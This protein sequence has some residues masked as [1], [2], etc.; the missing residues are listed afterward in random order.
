MNSPSTTTRVPAIVIGAG[1]NGLGVAR[2]LARAGAPAWLADDDAAR[3]ELR[4]RAARPLALAA[5]HGDALVEGLIRLGTTRFAGQRPVLLLTQEETVR[6]IS[7]QRAR[8]ADLYRFTLPPA[9]TVEALQHK[10]GFQQLAERFGAPIPPLVRVQAEADLAALATLQYP[11]VVKP[12]A[13]N[14]AYS[15]RFRKAYRI[16]DAAAATKLVREILPVLADVVVQEWTEGPDSNIYFCLQYLDA[17]G[18]VAASFTGR[19][20]RS[21][22]PQVGGTASCMPAP[23]ADAELRAL[24]TKF[25]RDT[26]V[27]GMAGMEYKRDVRSGRFRMVEP[28]I[29]RTDYQAEVA[30]LNGVNL[31]YAAYCCETGAPFPAPRAAARAFAWRVRSE[32]LQSAQAQHQD[33]KAGFDDVDAISDALWR[34]NDPWPAIVSAQ[35]HVAAALRTRA[36][37]LLPLTQAAGSKP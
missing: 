22:P 2:S 31:P 11:V 19:K 7:T 13:R 8:L 21:W 1:I 28:T 6:T 34:W 14:D 23:A 33:A 29:G 16:E 27:T 15:H 17:E 9:A 12:G 3:V 30:S 35:R 10:S 36:S 37:R 24:T 4:T 5:L 32:D 20:V 25:F 26:G 18:K